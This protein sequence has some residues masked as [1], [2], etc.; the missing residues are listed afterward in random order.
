MAGK[1]M[2]AGR[3]GPGAKR[4]GGAGRQAGAKAGAKTGFWASDLPVQAP[5]TGFFD[6]HPRF[7]ETSTVAADIAR[8]NFRHHMIIE[9][10]RA[11]LEGHRV[12]DIASHDSRFSFAALEAGAQHVISIEARSEPVAKARETFR[13]YGIEEQRYRLEE[14]DIYEFLPTLEAGSVDTAMVLGFLYHTAR[15][16]ELFAQLDRIGVR[17]VIVD[18]QV[19]PGEA[20]PLLRLRW[21]GTQA[22]GQIWDA[23]RKRVLSSIPSASALELYMQEFGWNT[24]RSAPAVAI[25]KSATVYRTGR[26][27]TIVG[28]RD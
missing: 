15:H 24:R 6:R 11:L 5:G 20:E 21:E 26:R 25:P 13:Q 17:N 12:L 10:N 3:K 14:G 22:D 4:K 1:G 9:Q 19:L 7:E 8:L 16:Y 18:S 28:T 27:V 2:R 23:T